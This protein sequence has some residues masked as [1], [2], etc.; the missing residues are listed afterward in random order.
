MDV[1]GELYLEYKGMEGYALFSE[2]H[3]VGNMQKAY[4]NTSAI[5]DKKRFQELGWQQFPGKV[6][7]YRELRSK[8]LD[9]EGELYLEYKGMEGYALFSERHFVGNM[10]K[11]YMNI[12]AILDKKRF[13]ELGWQAFQGRVSEYKE[14]KSKILDVEGELYLEYKGMEGYALFSE[15]HFVGNMQKAYMNISA[16][17]GGVKS[18]RELGLDWKKFQ[19]SVN[20]FHALKGLFDRYTVKQLKGSEGQGQVAGKIFN[21]DRRKTYDNVS[22]LR[23]ELLGDRK[24]FNEL[25]WIRVSQ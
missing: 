1:E 17:L 7:E 24:A 25:K 8:V 19:G 11:A 23:E 5:L 13:Q 14:L 2:R 3:F 21:G 9:V 20:Q 15:R 12:S 4:V 22:I 16:I 6:S 10:Q 18:V